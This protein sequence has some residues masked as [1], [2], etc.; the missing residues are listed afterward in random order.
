MD[1][2]TYT[3]QVCGKTYTD[4]YV[5]T[6]GHQ[7]EETGKREPTCD[8]EDYTIYTCK[9]CGDEKEDDY[10]DPLGHQYEEIERQDATCTEEGY[11]RYVCNVCR[12]GY[13]E[14]IFRHIISWMK[15]AY[16]QYARW[17]HLI[18]SGMQN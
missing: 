8:E 16:V 9:I 11:I 5:E 2:T 3:C 4:D 7:Y 13:D 17:N 10:V 18:R 1:N 14:Y 12:Y 15:A 6:T